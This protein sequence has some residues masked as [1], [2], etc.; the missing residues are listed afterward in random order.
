MVITKIIL[1]ISLYW[2]IIIH[3][4]YLNFVTNF[5]KSLRN[6]SI[7]LI[8]SLTFQYHKYLPIFGNQVLEWLTVSEFVWKRGFKPN[9]CL[10]K[11]KDRNNLRIFATRRKHKCSCGHFCVRNYWVIEQ[12]FLFTLNRKTLYYQILNYVLPLQLIKVSI[13]KCEKGCDTFI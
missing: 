13:T 7:Q 2:I 4:Q 11:Q 12:Q 10:N 5:S 1:M 8:F 9:I 6:L 3:A